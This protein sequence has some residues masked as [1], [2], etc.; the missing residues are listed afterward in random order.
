MILPHYQMVKD[1]ELDG[2]RLYEDI[3]YGDSF[4]KEFL[5]LPDGSYLMIVDGKE[6]VRGEAYRIADGE[7]SRI[8]EDGQT[9]SWR[10]L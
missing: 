9:I 1:R 5:A 4:G 2:K 7:I 3:T 10:I 6:T 8:C